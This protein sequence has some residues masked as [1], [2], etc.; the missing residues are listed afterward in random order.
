MRPTLFARQDDF[1][2]R[3]GLLTQLE[4]MCARLPTEA[5]CIALRVSARDMIL[6]GGMS[7][8]FQVLVLR[9]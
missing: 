3:A 2:L 7:H 1:L 9:K 5:E 6:P 8:S 4:Q